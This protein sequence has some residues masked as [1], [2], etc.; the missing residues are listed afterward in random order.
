MHN[1]GDKLCKRITYTAWIHSTRYRDNEH[2]VVKLYN[3][4]DQCKYE[5]DLYNRLVDIQGTY[6]PTCLYRTV[7]D[8][9]DDNI[10][11]MNR[12]PEY[13]YALITEYIQPKHNIT[14]ITQ[15]HIQ[16]TK[17]ILHSLHSFGVS[18]NDV[19]LDNIILFN[20]TTVYLID[21]SHAVYMN[22][23]DQNE[24]ID[25]CRKDIDRADMLNKYIKQSTLI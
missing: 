4:I 6:I 19:R 24:W 18:H 3:D 2:V 20:A 14:D 10:V 22:A 16:N 11:S 25:L 12:H 5:L 15:Y 1:N 8:V 17:L 9:Y 21:F 7:L 13:R 23:V